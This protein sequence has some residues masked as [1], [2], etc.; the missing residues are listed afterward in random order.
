MHGKR[1]RSMSCIRR[2]FPFFVVI[3][4]LLLALVSS[5]CLADCIACWKLKGVVV[6]L[7][8]GTGIK[9]YATWNDGWQAFEEGTVRTKKTFPEV[10][11]DPRVGIDKISVYT[12]LRSIKY[13]VKDALV[14][15]RKPVSLSVKD[16]EDLKLDPGPHDGY[17]G[18]GLLPLVSPRV[19]DLLQT[20]PVASCHYDGS[21]V[22][23]YWVSYD[24]SFPAG[25]LKRLCDERVSDKEIEKNLKA[26]DVFP[27]FFSYD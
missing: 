23:V 2:S 25:E 14:A 18:A 17:D 10:I 21:V 16:I 4:L 8:D 24:E 26:R 7:K 6:R 11:F 22:D 5:D 27:L 15:I 1:D 12:H 13:P 3:A 19:A 20:K 9:G